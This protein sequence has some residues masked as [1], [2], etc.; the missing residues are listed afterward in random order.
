[1]PSR[2]HQFYAVAFEENFS[3]RQIAPAFPEAR[4]SPLEMFVPI[5]SDGGLYIFPFGAIVSHDVP[6]EHRERIFARLTRAMPKLTTR[7]IREDYSVL[8]DPAAP[9]GISAGMLRVDKLTSQRAGIVAL[10]VGQSAAMEYY[11]RIVDSLFARTAQLV[12]RMASHGT[13]PYRITPLHRFIGE[14]ISSRTEVLAVLHL[15]DKPDAAW[16]DPAMD[17]IY[18]DLRDEFDLVDR[19]AAL[20]SKL[21]SIQD[22]L[23]LVLDV[24]R[25]RRLVLLEVVVALLIL[26]EIILGVIHFTA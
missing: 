2:V 8:E 12:D 4:I 15:L 19:Y 25:D 24:A 7:I 13:V 20:T 3:L 1:M 9:I 10:T 6:V 18:D 21:Q 11:E 23:V 17:L 26:L 5:E 16:E 22:S 14:A